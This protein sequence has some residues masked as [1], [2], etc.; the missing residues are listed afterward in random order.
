MPRDDGKIAMY[1]C[2]PTVYNFIHIGNARCYVAFD[3]IVRYLESTGYD[4]TYV[5]NLTDIDDKI[6]NRAQEENSTSSE[7]AEKYAKAFHEDMEV[8]GCRKPDIEPKATEEIP[9]MIKLIEGLIE[10]GFAYAVDGDVF[11]EI[12]KFTGYGKL[13]HRTLDEMRAGE[14]VEVDPRKHHPMDFALWK[15]A[16][17]GE[18]SWPSSWGDGRP[19][20]HIECS[21]MS[22]NRLGMSFD[23]HGGGQDLIFPHH[24]NEIAQAEAYTGAEPFVRYW[25]HNGFVTIRA[26]KM[27]KSVGNVILI[28]DLRDEYKGKEIELRNALRMLFLSTHYRSPIDYSDEHLEEAKRKVSGLLDLVWRVDDLLEKAVFAE[29]EET[30][31]AEEVFGAKISEAEKKFAEAMDDDFNTPAAI[32]VLFELERATNI[33][34]DGHKAG[35]SLSGKTLLEDAKKTLVKLSED[36]TGFVLPG[37]TSSSLGVF[38]A[39]AEEVKINEPLLQLAHEFIDASAY[40]SAREDELIS[41]L[42][43]KREEAR[44]EKNFQA[45][46]KIR[47]GLAEIGVTIEDTAYGARW[48]RK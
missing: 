47:A 21:A 5:R 35:F 42:V 4:V 26:E 30:V 33:F 3:A 1:V 2:G 23:I 43:E 12:S 44:K 15:N 22:L 11:Y 48:K 37:R 7:I 10:K 28:R 16:K 27:A 20:W 8:L 31:E 34:I 41:Q 39:G 32:G 46:D 24:E 13:S 40:D 6:I 36:V 38:A 45:A 19:G 17:P 18:P 9:E 25:L 14:R 29:T